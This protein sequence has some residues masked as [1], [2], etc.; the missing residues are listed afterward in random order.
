MKRVL[1][2]FGFMS[3]LFSMNGQ[4]NFGPWILLAE[5]NDVKI[6]RSYSTCDGELKVLLKVENNGA[7]NYQV[8]FDSAFDL[9][10]SILPVD[11]PKQII[12]NAGSTAGGNCQNPDLSINPFNYITSVKLGESDYVI[13]NLQIVQL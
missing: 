3:L 9:D 12:V 13:Q 1:I 11:L 2:L 10:G 6:Y 4:T 7:N 8:S 5:Q